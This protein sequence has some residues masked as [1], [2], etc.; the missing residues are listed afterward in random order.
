MASIRALKVLTMARPEKR[1][2][3]VQPLAS[4]GWVEAVGRGGLWHVREGPYMLFCAMEEVVLA[5]QQVWGNDRFEGFKTTVVSAVTENKDILFQWCMLTAE[6]EDEDAR[7]VFG[8]LVH[9]DYHK[10][11]FVH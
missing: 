1:K 7:V 6:T 3:S 2:E 5:Q 10:R 4:A 8:M 9:L 11:I